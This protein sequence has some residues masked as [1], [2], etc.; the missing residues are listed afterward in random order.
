MN[1][2]KDMR[3]FLKVDSSMF[4]LYPNYEPVIS[5]HEQVKE[6]AARV[7]N[8]STAH[9]LQNQELS[10]LI[11]RSLILK[12]TRLSFLQQ[13]VQL[14]CSISG[15]HGALHAERKIQTL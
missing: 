7:N 2:S 3:Y 4:S 12:V 6:L 10:L 9:L 14:F 11:S 8:D 5:L 15:H 13:E 1:P